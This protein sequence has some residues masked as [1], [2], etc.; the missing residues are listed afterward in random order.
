VVVSAADAAGEGEIFVRDEGSSMLY[1]LVFK[2]PD[3]LAAGLSHDHVVR[4][5]GWTGSFRWDP[6]DPKACDVQISVPVDKLAVDEPHMRKKVGFESTVKDS[7]RAKIKKTMLGEKQLY[8]ETHP[9]ISFASRK[10]TGMDGGVVVAGMFELRGKKRPVAIEMKVAR[11]GK[12]LTATGELK[13]KATDFGF[14]AFSAGLGALKNQ[15][16]MKLTVHF[17]GDSK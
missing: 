12:R 14:D 13:L 10:C 7:D 1:I 8:S 2:D 15:N 3:T 9:T 5:T 11:Q 4:A 16:E 17:V 6:K